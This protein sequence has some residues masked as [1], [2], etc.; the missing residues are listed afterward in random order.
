[1]AKDSEVVIDLQGVA[2]S[3]REGDSTSTRRILTSL[4]FTARAGDFVAI[5]GPSGSGKSTLLNLLA[6]LDRPDTGTV[7]V[8]GEDLAALGGDACTRHRRRYIGLV[9][10]FFNLVPTLTVTENLQLPLALNGIDG[11]GDRI[12]SMLSEFGLAEQRN[13]YPGTLSG[14]E[15]QRLAVLRAAVHGPPVVL[16]DEPTGN[17]DRERGEAVIALL[18]SLAEQGTCVVMATHSRRAASA[19]G[20]RLRIADGVLGPWDW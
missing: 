16:A 10:Q 17:L 6:G 18:G 20:R 19:A 1:M 8:A 12:D 7:R 9:F 15:Q 2:K 4:D 13:A 14:G 5:G 11:P 3:Y